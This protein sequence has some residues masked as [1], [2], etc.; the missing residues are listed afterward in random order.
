VAPE[1]VPPAIDPSQ[2]PRSAR[3]PALPDCA[4]AVSAE[5][6]AT[7]AADR[8]VPAP[9]GER[10][11][12]VDR[13]TAEQPVDPPPSTIV[14]PSATEAR[15]ERAR[16]ADHPHPDDPEDA[17]PSTDAADTPR[18][19]P[20]L[21]T[22]LPSP[23]T[24]PAEP[25]AWSEAGIVSAFGGLF[26]LVHVIDRLTPDPTIDAWDRLELITLA[27]LGHRERA[28]DPVWAALAHLAGRDPNGSL[29]PPPS[30]EAAIAEAHARFA[31]LLVDVPARV[32]VSRTHVD[33][34]QRL[35]DVSLP[36]RLAGLDRDPGWRHSY[37]RVLA[38]HF[39]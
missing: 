8:D 29:E 1:L 37:R 33:V 18:S 17:D 39:L 22:P 16:S 5:P 28:P 38:F 31:R 32:Y 25:E 19:P 24:A 15:V 27:L 10:R 35:A 21:A 6:N 14:V 12:P 3:Q 34:V 23:P 20:Q 13:S 2:P 26:H 11:R 7:A 30:I 36:L 4:R 9:W